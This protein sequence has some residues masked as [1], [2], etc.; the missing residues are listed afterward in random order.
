MYIQFMILALSDK[1]LDV[2]NEQLYIYIYMRDINKE[3][4]LLHSDSWVELNLRMA[5]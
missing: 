3:K 5:L 2:M 4:L 1:V